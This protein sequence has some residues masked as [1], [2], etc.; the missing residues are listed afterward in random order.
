MKK[1][2]ANSARNKKIIIAVAVV[3]VLI[4]ILVLL[5]LRPVKNY[6]EKY[7][8][9]NLDVEVKGMERTGTYKQYVLKHPDAA[10]PNSTIDINLSN[11]TAIGEVSNYTGEKA[12]AGS[13]LTDVG[14]V[15]TWTVNV[16][17]AG[18]YNIE[19]EYFLPKSHGIP[20]ERSLKINGEEPFLDAQNLSFSRIWTNN[21]DKKIDN[22]G[23]EIRP[24]QTEV[25]DWQK[26]WFQDD[27]GYVAEPYMFYF[28]SGNNTITLGGENEP[29]VIK[30][31]ALTPVLDRPTYDQYYNACYNSHNPGSTSDTAKNYLSV[32]QGED[33]TI[34]SESSLYAKYDRSSPST[35]P[36]SVTTTVLNYIGGESWNINGQWIEW[37]FDV[38][39]DGFYNLTIKAR[40]NY[41]RGNV[42]NR[43]V[44]IDGE[45]P[46]K[47]LEQISFPYDNNWELLTIGV[48]EENPYYFW[49]KGNTYHQA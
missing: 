22:Q 42:S 33:S 16:A 32:V 36:N 5:S 39:E 47:E 48:D 21:G 49:L 46:F 8:G 23:N 44:Y 45:I 43:K 24:S 3:V 41:S 6:S 40:Q 37:N 38:P 35:Q 28:N 25:Y 26:T 1:K 12:V 9:T 14:S 15:V 2:K 18:F 4:A 11:Y 17:E 10:K 34:R 29:V 27:R 20:A 13:I 19:M 7:A 30:R 31:L